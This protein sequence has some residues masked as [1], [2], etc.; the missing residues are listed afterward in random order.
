MPLLFGE[1]MRRL[2]KGGVGE[3]NLEDVIEYNGVSI[4]MKSEE[5]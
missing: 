2:G 4:S 3:Y 5:M 1:K